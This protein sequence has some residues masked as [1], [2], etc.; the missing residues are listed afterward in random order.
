MKSLSAILRPAYHFLAF[1][2]LY[3]AR[4][5]RPVSTSHNGFEFVIQ[6]SVMHPRIFK[7]GR[8]LARYL[9]SLDLRGKHVLDLGTGSGILALLA[10]GQ[11]ARVTATDINP[12][13]VQCASENIRRNGYA[14]AT[15][16]LEGSL[17]D[18]LPHEVF[19]MIIFNPPY[20]DERQNTSDD[21]AL[22]G[23]RNLSVIKE[24]SRQAAAFLKPGGYLLLILSSDADIERILRMFSECKFTAQRVHQH[25]TLFEDF[26]V[27]KFTPSVSMDDILHCPSCRGALVESRGG[28]E[29]R[30]ESFFFET[31]DGIPDF[32]LPS[33]QSILGR[34]LNTYQS[35]RRKERWGDKD[36]R[37][38]HEL[39]YRD[40]SN[41]H[42]DMWAIRA[43]SYDCLIDHLVQDTHTDPQKILDLGAGNCWLSLR[44]AR[45]G[46]SVTGV[47]A[48]TDPED[49]LGVVQRL[50][51]IGEPGFN[52]VRAE[53][54]FLPF[55]EHSFEVI[56]FN[57][58]LHYAN[59]PYETIKKMMSLLKQKGCIYIVDS[60]IYRSG[61]SG[62][63]MMKE[64]IESFSH[65][66]RETLTSEFAGSYL[67]FTG[68]D[69]L[70]ALYAVDMFFPS[71]G[72][73]WNLRPFL[74]R[75]RGRRPPARFAL[76][77]IR[78]RN[79]EETR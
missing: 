14:S 20:F 28:W 62:E 55:A 17:F 79:S 51:D 71:Y 10:A 25:Q 24:F 22:Y 70:R 48:N 75:L 42:S 21:P 3:R 50:R 32:I 57:A 73:V 6:P 8:I 47:D 18:P 29:C 74:A 30:N 36:P 45:L 65:D 9:S 27:Y 78:N 35:V 68:L 46:Y 67:T 66:E 34:F 41:E 4:L 52:L 43:K 1:N 56:I 69:Q 38:Y 54:D 19:D 15:R 16:V 61:E 11:G 12:Q 77:R 40:L 59:D 49:G 63:A 5:K 33:R 2:L 26:F 53:F 23:G 37:Y 64:R 72:L 76:I 44:L 31:V 39:P 60:P 7:S 58:S 13:A